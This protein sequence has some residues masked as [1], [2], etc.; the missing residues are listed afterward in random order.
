MFVAPGE[1]FAG[2]AASKVAAWLRGVA[3]DRPGT[4][5]VA[6]AGG[7]TPR[8]VYEAMAAS[9]VPWGRLEIFFGDERAVQPDDPESNYRMA[10]ASL[11]DRVPISAAR[12]HRMRGEADALDAAADEY[13]RVLPRALDLV[14]LGIG[15]DG[16]TASLF[17]GD[18]ALHADTPVAPATAPSPPR[19]RLTLTPPVLGRAERLVVL[20]TGGA[21]AE[22]V[23]RA[24]LG[25]WAPEACPA[26]LARRGTWLLDTDSA[27]ELPS[28]LCTE[29]TGA[30]RGSA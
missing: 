8:P 5:A 23:A 20:A 2:W 22:P 9:A 24:L 27:S 4:V 28:S 1:S 26:Q 29:A 14:L 3:E 21:K 7:N 17:P 11:L 12:V 6:L 15:A 25:A 16:H 13:A 19:R 10:R 30:P 18:A